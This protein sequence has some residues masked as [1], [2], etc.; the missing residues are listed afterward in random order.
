MQNRIQI[1]KEVSAERLKQDQMWGGDEHDD[2]HNMRDWGMFIVHELGQI[3]FYPPTY[4]IFRKQ[5]VKVAALAIAA[6]EWTE[7]HLE[8]TSNLSKE[9][10]LTEMN[11]IYTSDA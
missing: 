2:T 9:E 4:T 8:R 1:Y 7:R 11:R 5:M 10:W 3:F 6:I